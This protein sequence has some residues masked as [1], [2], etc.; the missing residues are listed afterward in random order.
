MPRG[1]APV[2]F[3]ISWDPR[4][5]GGGGSLGIGSP[6]AEDSPQPSTAPG[7]ALRRTSSRGVLRLSPTLH[8]Q[9]LRKRLGRDVVG[10]AADAQQ[11]Q[12]LPL[13]QQIRDHH[14]SQA[15]PSQLLDKGAR[16]DLRLTDEQSSVGLRVPSRCE[17]L[18][19]HFAPPIDR[20]RA[21]KGL[22]RRDVVDVEPAGRQHRAARLHRLS[23]Y[24]LRR[25]QR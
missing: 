22:Q 18:G 2:S 3:G 25:T 14:H 1:T 10:Q 16:D 12:P 7:A 4:E 9:S 5:R 24:C 23:P 15:A 19:K 13:R 20:H 6:D 8:L 21:L 11:A 17:Q